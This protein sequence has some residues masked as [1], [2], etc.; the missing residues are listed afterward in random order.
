[1][2]CPKC[3]NTLQTTAHSQLNVQKCQ[4]CGGLLL[5]DGSFEL[6]RSLKDVA[7]LDAPGEFSTNEMRDIECPE[8]QSKMLHMIDR[9]QH[10]IEFEACTRCDNVFLDAGELTDLTDFTVFERVKQALGTAAT[11]LKRG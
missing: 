5:K 1:M 3:H 11:N 6:A 4:G 8:C 10:H 9:T 7:D 2:D